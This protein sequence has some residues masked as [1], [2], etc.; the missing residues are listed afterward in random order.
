MGLFRYGFSF[1]DSSI[2]HRMTSGKVYLI[3][4]LRDALKLG[5]KEAKDI[6][7]ALDNVGGI[8]IESTTKLYP[9]DYNK[10]LYEFG[11]S[12]RLI[13]EVELPSDDIAMVYVV[14]K[15]SDM[16]EG[17]GP[18]LAESIFT[19]KPAAEEYV[20]SQPG[21]MGYKDGS[22]WDIKEMPLFLSAEQREQTNLAEQKAKAL[23]KLTPFERNLLGV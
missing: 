12:I 7:D 23:A 14:R 21:I 5:L 8:E 19:N 16:T 4:Q 17:R 3:K 15:N 1:S 6:A 13:A 11:V 2:I 9:A 20:A 22:G 10:F 18:M